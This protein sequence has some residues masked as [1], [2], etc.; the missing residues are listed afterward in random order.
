MSAIQDF[1]ILQTGDGKVNILICPIDT[2]V[3]YGSFD[4]SQAFQLN[5]P[6]FYDLNSGDVKDYILEGNKFLQLKYLYVN[7]KGN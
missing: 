7:S 3:G 1:E 6:S 4:P 5:N 2:G